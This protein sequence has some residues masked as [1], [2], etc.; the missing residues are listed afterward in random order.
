MIRGKQQ[1]PKV[2]VSAYRKSENTD[3]R[4]V[5]QPEI[6]H[7]EDYP[8]GAHTITWNLLTSGYRF[9]PTPKKPSD[10]RA[11]E[12]TSPG[13]E[14]SFSDLKVSECGHRAT[15]RN[16]NCDGLAF[17]YNVNVVEASTGETVFLDPVVQ[18]NNP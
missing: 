11:I 4:L 17:A 18:N 15:V 1:R 9:P 6:L 7:M 10:L 13:W 12:F 14:K 5:V 3:P 8:K 16:K 2:R